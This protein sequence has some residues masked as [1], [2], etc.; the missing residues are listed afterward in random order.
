M[1]TGVVK[2]FEMDKPKGNMK[3]IK[4]VDCHLCGYKPL[5]EF[6]NEVLTF[7]PK[8]YY[9]S[10]SR[11]NVWDGT[12]NQSYF[13]TNPKADTSDLGVV[14][15]ACSTH[16]NDSKCC[17]GDRADEFTGK[18]NFWWEIEDEYFDKDLYLHD[19]ICERYQEHK[20]NSE[21]WQPQ[22]EMEIAMGKCRYKFHKDRTG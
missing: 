16:I 19:H 13:N 5:S 21:C 14:C 18:S 8:D 4:K 1:K 10:V 15:C 2:L 17:V 9:R 22:S 11:I 3:G 6:A 7:S 12:D 20:R